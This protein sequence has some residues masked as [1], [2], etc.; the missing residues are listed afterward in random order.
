[1]DD[2]SPDY[3]SHGHDIHHSNE[4]VRLVAN[5][6]PERFISKITSIAF[7]RLVMKFSGNQ[8]VKSMEISLA[9]MNTSL[10][11]IDTQLATLVKLESIA[12]CIV[13]VSFSFLK[14]GYDRY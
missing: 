10:A 12:V 4:T 1:M 13:L 3:E 5:I 2:N 8:D 9:S 14:E 6:S 11:V 7:V